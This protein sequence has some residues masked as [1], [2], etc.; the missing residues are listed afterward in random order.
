M[1]TEKLFPITSS[2]K[3]WFKNYKTNSNNIVIYR[4]SFA[5]GF[6]IVEIRS[7]YI[8]EKEQILIQF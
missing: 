5:E 2:N 1:I 6:Y 4:E 3:N 8:L 7:D